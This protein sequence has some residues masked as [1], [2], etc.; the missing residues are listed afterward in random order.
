M[1]MT[2]PAT[3]IEAEI[4]AARRD[5]DQLVEQLL[6]EDLLH[7]GIP[8]LRPDAGHVDACAKIKR[9]FERAACFRAEILRA[10]LNGYMPARIALGELVQEVDE[11]KQASELK[12][13]AKA[14]A[15]PHFRWPGKS[16]A[17]R[18]AHVYSDIAM[19]MVLLELSK[20]FPNIRTTGHS[21]RQTC[22]CDIVAEIFSKHRDRIGRGRVAR[23]QVKQIW[24]RYKKLAIHRIR[25]PEIVN[26]FNRLPG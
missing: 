6:T 23:G 20:R 3:L 18:L 10:A 17:K 2:L 25:D 14:C 1:A 26:A 22:H 7:I 16:G 11:D 15:N 21:A 5:A 24:K 13:F 19:V 8:I 4:A 12:M 9:L